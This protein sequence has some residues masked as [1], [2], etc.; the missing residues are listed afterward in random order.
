[1][2]ADPMKTPIFSPGVFV[3]E[4]F[5]GMERYEDHIVVWYFDAKLGDFIEGLMSEEM[6]LSI[7]N[8]LFIVDNACMEMIKRGKATVGVGGSLPYCRDLK[9]TQ[10]MYRDYYSSNEY[11]INVCY[12]N[13]GKSELCVTSLIIDEFGYWEAIQSDWYLIDKVKKKDIGKPLSKWVTFCRPNSIFM[14]DVVPFACNYLFWNTF[15]RD[16]AKSNKNFGIGTANG[17]IVYLSGRAKSSSNWFAFNPSLSP[18]DP[19]SVQRNSLDF[20]HIFH[21]WTKRHSSNNGYLQV[22]KIQG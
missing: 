1:E 2:N 18:N 8:P 6:S 3:N 20:T 17:T 21:Y 4:E 13:S 14:N 11:Q 16:W 12:E 9:A 7:S 22:W 5:V 10:Q 15:E 19:Q